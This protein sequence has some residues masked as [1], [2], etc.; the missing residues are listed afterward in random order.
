[1][2]GIYFLQKNKN[3]FFRC[4]INTKVCMVDP[5]GLTLRHPKCKP[6]DTRPFTVPKCLED[7]LRKEVGRLVDDC[8]TKLNAKRYSLLFFLGENTSINV[9]KWELKL[10]LMYFNKL[11]IKLCKHW[12]MS[13]LT[14]MTY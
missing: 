11:C 5:I 12:K 4:C 2:D 10:Q 13:E 6:L 7:Q 3:K 1:M 14:Y 8:Q 9:S